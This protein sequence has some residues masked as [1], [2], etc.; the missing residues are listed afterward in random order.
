MKGRNSS[1][2]NIDFNFQKFFTNFRKNLDKTRSLTLQNKTSNAVDTVRIFLAADYACSKQT[3]FVKIDCESFWKGGGNGE[4]LCDYTFR[5]VDYRVLLALE[6]EWGTFSSP[7][8]TFDKVMYD[9]I[10]IINMA[11]PVKVM[12]YAYKNNNEELLEGMGNI[13]T[14]FPVESIGTL[15]AIGCP[16]D[17]ELYGKSI[18]GKIWSKYH[19]EI[20]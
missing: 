5:T 12:V 20:I 17:D 1:E 3:E 15:I 10:K 14:K 2:L 11:A 7:K 19:W 18:S 6:S 8:Q 9:F 4:F 13:V 16:W